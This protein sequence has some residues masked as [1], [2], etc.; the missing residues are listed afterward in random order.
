M[1]SKR[2]STARTPQNLDHPRIQTKL[3]DVPIMYRGVYRRAMMGN[4]LRAAINAQCLECFQ[5]QREE[6]PKCTAIDCPLY[7]Y[8]PYQTKSGE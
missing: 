8:R 5:W 1:K 2:T 6:I 7:P 3:K 4:D